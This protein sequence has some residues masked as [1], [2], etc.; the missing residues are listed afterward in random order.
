MRFV[1]SDIGPPRRRTLYNICMHAD[2]ITQS[3][4]SV[5]IVDYYY[6]V[7]IVVCY[8][9]REGTPRRHFVEKRGLLSYED[10]MQ[11]DEYIIW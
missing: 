9:I 6:S 10:E 3:S 5:I 8:P 11:L 2:Y 7:L 4:L 1:E